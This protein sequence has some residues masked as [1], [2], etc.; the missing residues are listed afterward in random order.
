MVACAELFRRHPGNPLLTA[1]DWPTAVNVV[2]N[3]A[4]V[5][6]DG[7]TVLLARVEALT[8]HL[9][10]DCRA[11]GERRRRLAHRR[12]PLL[13]PIKGREPSSGA[14]RTRAAVWVDELGRS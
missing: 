4:A 3:P 14:S 2:F 13:A 12:E 1:D 10:L 8:G 5:D 9:A 7:E 6:V 11:L